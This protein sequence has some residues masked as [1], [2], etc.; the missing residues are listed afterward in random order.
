MTTIT[1]ERVLTIDP[2]WLALLLD[3]GLTS[4]TVEYRARALPAA[5]EG[6]DVALHC[7]ATGKGSMREAARMILAVA[8]LTT[9]RDWACERCK[10][11]RAATENYAAQTGRDVSRWTI[12]W[13]VDAVRF[14]KPVKWRGNVGLRATVASRWR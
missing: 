6:T 2:F 1:P 5:G 4:K 12:G 8:R 10:L 11:S 3:G 9:C 13:H 14:V 7:A